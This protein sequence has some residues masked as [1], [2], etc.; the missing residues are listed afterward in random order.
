MDMT[1][2]DIVWVKGGKYQSVPS[3]GDRLLK[4]WNLAQLF[5]LNTLRNTLL[6]RQGCDVLLLT[7]APQDFDACNRGRDFFVLR[8][9]VEHEQPDGIITSG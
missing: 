8:G 5:Y 9:R 6:R 3:S 4:P 7:T 2:V 1:G